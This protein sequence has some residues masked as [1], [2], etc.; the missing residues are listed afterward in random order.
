[1]ES[2]RGIS[3]NYSV[4]EFVRRFNRVRKMGWVESHRK[5]NTGIGK[6]LEDLLEIEENNIHGP[7][8]GDVEIKSQRSLTSSKLTLFTKVP[9]GPIGANKDLRDRYGKQN[10]THP[11]LLQLHAS[12]F[13]KWNNT[14]DKW[15]MRMVPNDEERRIYLEI[16]N[17]ETNSIENYRCWY[18]Y[19]VIE[20]VISKKMNILAFVSADS[21]TNERDREELRFTDCKI[22]Y[23]S[24]LEKFLKLMD[25]G[26]IQFDIRIGSYKT[27]GKK[28]G[29]VHDHGSGFRI[30]RGNM[31]DL[32]EGYIEI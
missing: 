8:L 20:N 27:P 21:R 24:T 31:V 3:E 28:Y 1:M 16:K 19:D 10:P 4:V 22:F 9:T 26:K 32:F 25:E 23:G 30:A 6:T 2:T 7:D 11:D 13:N 5:H 17:L 15:G 14:F 29:K 18:D 12:M